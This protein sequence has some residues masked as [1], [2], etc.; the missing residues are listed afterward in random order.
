MYVTLPLAVQR[1]IAAADPDACTEWLRANTL[2]VPTMQD[3]MSVS[4]SSTINRFFT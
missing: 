4:P 1:G 2:W 3:A